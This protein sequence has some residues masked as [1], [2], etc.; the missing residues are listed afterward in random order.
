MITQI[1][2][3]ELEILRHHVDTNLKI[4]NTKINFF[5]DRLSEEDK[6]EIE[7]YMIDN[8]D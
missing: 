8:S 1:T 4:L 3:I 6:K 7:E 5:V 2:S